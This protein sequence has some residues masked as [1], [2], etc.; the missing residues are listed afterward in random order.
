MTTVLELKQNNM[1]PLGLVN[2]VPTHCPRCSTDES[3]V[4]LGINDNWK[5]I[6]CPNELCPTYLTKRIE[7]C[8]KTLLVLGFGPSVCEDVV[9]THNITTIRQIYDLCLT[10]ADT[11]TTM[12]SYDVNMALATKFF[13]KLVQPLSI[14]V[15]SLA[16][17]GI[18]TSA[19]KLLD[20][21]ND[22]EDF[23]TDFLADPIGMVTSRLNIS[24]G[25]RVQSVITTLVNH[26]PAILEHVA[27]F[28]I[29][30]VASETLNIAIT[31]EVTGYASK[32]YFVQKLN[33]AFGQ[34]VNIIL[35]KSIT[36]DLAFLLNDSGSTTTKITKAMEYNTKGSNIQIVNSE[37]FINV[38]SQK[39]GSV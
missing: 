36:R 5:K 15:K 23:Y 32:E 27:M 29:K 22:I 3:P 35:K 11:L 21:Y 10:S 38:L 37:Q 12:Y 7:H 28:Q 17:T 14:A 25:P 24:F 19:D 4:L 34:K 2:Y 26:R 8:M 13:D 30:L 33:E 31:E 9:Y 20:G 16:L 39:Y 18:D 1:L 6:S